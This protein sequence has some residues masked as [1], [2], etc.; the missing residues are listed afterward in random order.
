MTIRRVTARLIDRESEDEDDLDLVEQAERLFRSRGVRLRSGYQ[1]F[2]VIE[3]DG[4]VIAAAALAPDEGFKSSEVEF[5]IVTQQDRERQGL[6][7]LLVLEVLK[8][9]KSWAREIEH[10]VVD[11]T[12]E[13][14]NDVAVPPLLRSL[15]FKDLGNGY[16]TN[17]ISVF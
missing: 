5:S 11:V 17:S 12:A 3:E 10:D 14:I 7:R 2:L 13:V 8:Y 9:A 6:A 16:W 4:G 15:G 1:S